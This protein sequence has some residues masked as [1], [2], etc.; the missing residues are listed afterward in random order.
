MPASEI[1]VHLG[2]HGCEDITNRLELSSIGRSVIFSG[3]FGDVYRGALRTGDRVA[4]KY[5]RMLVTEDDSGEKQ[6]KRTAHELYIWSKC[7]HTNIL[8]LIGVAQH[9]NQIAMVSP[10][11]ENGNMNWYLNRHPLVDRYNLCSQIADA[12][13]YLKDNDIVHGDIKGANILVSGDH[14]PKLTDFGSSI[15]RKYTLGFTTTTTGTSTTLRWTAPEIFMEETKHT[16]EGD[17]YALGMTILEAFTESVPYEDLL[18]VAVMRRL[19]QRVHPERPQRCIPVGDRSSDLLWNVITSCWDKH[20]QNRP[21][22][23]RVR[24]KAIQICEA[25]DYLHSIDIV[26]GAIN[27][28]NILVS[29]GSTIQ[30]SGFHNAFIRNTPMVFPNRERVTIVYA[31]LTDYYTAPELYNLGSLLG[32]TFETDVYAL[33]METDYLG[34]NHNG[35]DWQPGGEYYIPENEHGDRLCSLVKECRAVEPEYRPAAIQVRDK[36]TTITGEGLWE[37]T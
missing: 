10:W 13:A 27:P 31:G 6:L 35:A 30:L 14:I 18:D 9:N 37:P 34:C 15:I 20:P 7:R 25:V 23:L 19:M 12:V 17:V 5:L 21:P 2:R 1:L 11:M 22:A 28:W 26:H 3:G 33:G 24:D 29:A 36:I 4:V 8:E 32:W 16:F